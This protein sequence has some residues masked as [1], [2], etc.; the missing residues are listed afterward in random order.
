MSARTR[1]RGLAKEEKMVS[2]ARKERRVWNKE[3]KSV[4]MAGIGRR[5]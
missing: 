2:A 4:S 1:V 5:K 3:A